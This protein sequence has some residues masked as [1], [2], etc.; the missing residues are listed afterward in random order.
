MQKIGSS[1]S[2][3]LID[4]LMGFRKL[5]WLHH[6][7]GGLRRSEFWVLI[8]LQK[9]QE[10]E[11]TGVR[12]SD[13]ARRLNVATPTATQLVKRLES[14]GHVERRRSD[15]D[16]R[17][18]QVILTKKGSTA[19][20]AAHKNVVS[21]FDAVVEHLGEKD[22]DKLAELLT[23]VTDFLRKSVQKETS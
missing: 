4:A 10:G 8:S 12:V 11:K 23:E 13:L 3:K 6:P 20:D 21:H 5:H 2:Q 1:R 19:V 22:S 17:I 18:V 9:T 16:R 14:T 15:E 7:V